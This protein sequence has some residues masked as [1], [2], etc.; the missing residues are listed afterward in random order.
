M[1]NQ[2]LNVNSANRV[3]QEEI[4]DGAVENVL[5]KTERNRII[6]NTSQHLLQAGVEINPVN[7][8]MAAIFLDL[9]NKLL[10][11]IDLAEDKMT[12]DEV[13]SVMDDILNM[14]KAL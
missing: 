9:G 13:Q 8:E 10:E 7:T 6:F 11:E 3:E 1:I 14:R 12:E 5:S 2:T 4:L